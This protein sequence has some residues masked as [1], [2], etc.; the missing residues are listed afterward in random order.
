MLDA[1]VCNFAASEVCSGLRGVN[2]KRQLRRNMDLVASL[3]VLHPSIHFT[4]A[5]T[6]TFSAAPVHMS[7]HTTLSQSIA[8]FGTTPPSTVN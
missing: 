2:D 1:Q 3:D 5:Y 4:L 8:A 6:F 7:L